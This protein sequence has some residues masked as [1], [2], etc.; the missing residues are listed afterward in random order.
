MSTNP[1]ASPGNYIAPPPKPPAALVYAP[2]TCILFFTAT[3][4]ALLAFVSVKVCVEV[5]LKL[6]APGKGDL[7]PREWGE[8][9]GTYFW[10]ILLLSIHAYIIYGAI[11]MLRLHGY[12]RALAA[13]ILSCVPICSGCLVVGIPFGIWA[14]IVL[15][16]PEVKAAFR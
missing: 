1:Y 3:W 12:R 7:G 9:I 14:L 10:P 6:T 8:L 4:M 5:T 2:A 16:R 13:A 15:Y 11:C